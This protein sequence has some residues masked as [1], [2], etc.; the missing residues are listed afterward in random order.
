MW[1][2]PAAGN[3][4]VL[5]GAEHFTVAL[6]AIKEPAKT[7]LSVE[8]MV[9]VKE[10]VGWG[11]EGNPSLLGLKN[12]WDSQLSWSQDTWDKAN[13][14]AF[15]DANSAKF[16]TDFPRDRWCHVKLT[17]HGDKQTL[18]VDGQPF[19]TKTGPAFKDNVKAP[20]Q[21]MFGPFRGMVDEVCVKTGND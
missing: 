15:G 1:M 18:F 13:A 6:P 21:L 11:Y 16:A 9:Y 19:A 5:D 4:L 7:P 12:D 2:D 14:P 3:C 8:M 10:F 17:S 20:V